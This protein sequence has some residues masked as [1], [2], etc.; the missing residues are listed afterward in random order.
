MSTASTPE[1]MLDAASK[2]QLVSGNSR[3][4]LNRGISYELRGVDLSV[5]DFDSVRFKNN[6]FVNCSASEVTF[7]DCTFD[8]CRFAAEGTGRGS[9][10]NAKFLN[11]SLTDT[12]FG[13]ARLDLGEIEFIHT[14]L[15]DCTFRLGKLAGARFERCYL[16]YV[17]LRSADL[18]GASFAGSV[19]RKVCFEKSDLSSVDFDGVSFQQGDFWGPLD[20]PGF[21]ELAAKG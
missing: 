4:L 19:L 7:T 15:R 20:I 13:A 3:V 12:S 5:V 8:N 18:Q 10:R 6:R 2:A 21:P 9:L 16:D 11:C 14:R 1:E 17:I